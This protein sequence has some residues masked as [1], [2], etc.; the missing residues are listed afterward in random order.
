MND[1]SV[2]SCRDTTDTPLTSHV[3]FATKLEGSLEQERKIRMDL[4]RAK[5]KLEGDLNITQEAVTDLENAKQ[6]S[7]E[8]VKK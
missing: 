8:L 4:E 3:L 2:S 7:E 6:Q 5:R 1:V